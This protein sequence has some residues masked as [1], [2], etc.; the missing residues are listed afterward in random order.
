MGRV[1]LQSSGRFVPRAC[2]MPGVG[3]CVCLCMC[4]FVKDSDMLL[5]Y[6]N[7]KIYQKNTKYNKTIL[8]CVCVVQI[9]Q[10][11]RWQEGEYR[12][13]CKYL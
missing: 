4:V 1:S 13:V 10:V 12:C 5:A 8:E 7:K 2:A 9:V 3:V 6:G 11:E